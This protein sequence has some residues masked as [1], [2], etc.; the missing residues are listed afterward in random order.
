MFVTGHVTIDAD[1]GSVVVPLS[2]VQRLDGE[3]VVFVAGEDGFMTR[4]VKLGRR[5]R[6][7]VEVLEG[8]GAGERY[9][10]SGAF[11]LKAEIITSGIDPHAGHG[12]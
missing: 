7:E 2:A 4:T 11:H 6:D 10:S 1:E 12:H 8:L 9:V 3:S 5:D